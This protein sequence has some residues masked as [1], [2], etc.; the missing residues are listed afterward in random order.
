MEQLAKRVK[1]VSFAPG[2]LSSK[3]GQAKQQ[4]HVDAINAHI[5]PGSLLDKA[6]A[7]VRAA[8]H[9]TKGGDQTNHATVDFTDPDTGAHITT[10]SSCWF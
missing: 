8:F 4:A 2:V 10:V 5:T 3:K 7:T 1:S 6:E 9:K